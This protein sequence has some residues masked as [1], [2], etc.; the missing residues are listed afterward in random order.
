MNKLAYQLLPDE[1]LSET[2]VYVTTQTY[3]RFAREYAE[4]W[5]WN[6]ITIREITKFNIAP[7]VKYAKKN[8]SVLL[9]NCQ[10]GRD[11]ALLSQKGF[12]CL[13]V[14]FSYGLLTEAIKRVPQGLFVRLNLKSLPFMPENFDVVYAD[15]LIHT[16]KK[17]MKE[18][19]RD[20]SIFLRPKGVLYLS[21]Q[22]GKNKHQVMVMED[23]GGK[24]YI[25]LYKK[26]EIMNLV[27]SAGFTVLWSKTSPHT[28][29][30]LPGW[31]S[32]IAK[33]L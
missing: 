12:V 9:V 33:K 10:S 6:P 14:G 30:S 25:T 24:L 32:L 19:F 15:A 20:F 16:P 3:D 18:L 28:D 17:E 7:V 13:G 2:Q 23:L 5:E 11:Y 22:L 4:K 8:G 21:L 29:A 27:K 26:P 31:F 1:D